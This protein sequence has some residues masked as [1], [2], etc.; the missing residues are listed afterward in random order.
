MG[1]NLTGW[2]EADRLFPLSFGD[3]LPRLDGLLSWSLRLTRKE[4]SDFRT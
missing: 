4:R 1:R 2:P 3:F